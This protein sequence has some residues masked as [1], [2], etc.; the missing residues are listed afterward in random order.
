MPVFA[1]A[2]A[3]VHIDS[4]LLG[5]AVT[6]P[7]TLGIF[8]GYVVGKPLGVL[9]ASWLASRPGLPACAAP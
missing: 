3:G 4:E 8:F 7:I 6:S 2:N 5:D 9:G 1:L